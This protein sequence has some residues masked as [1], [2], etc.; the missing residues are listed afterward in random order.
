MELKLWYERQAEKWT[1]AMP[2][3]N[4]R[5]GAMVHGGVKEEKI[6]FNEDTLWS[7]YPHDKNEPGMHVYYR[8][9][10][11][12]AREHRYK[13]AQQ[14][15]EEQFTGG[16]TESYMP[17]GDMYLKMEHG[18]GSSY[19][20]ELDLRTG[21]HKVSYRADGGNYKRT[22][23][24]SYPAQ[25]FVM[26]LESERKG[27]LTFS[28]TF[29]SQLKYTVSSGEGNLE[30]RGLCPSHAD[31]HYLG[32]VNAIFYSDK[33]EE[34]GIRYFS[35]IQVEAADG[36]VESRDGE[37][38]VS[39][40]TEALICLGVRSNFAGI[41][42]CPEFA[43]KDYE[44]PCRRDVEAAVKKGFGALLEEQEKD[45][46]SYFDRVSFSLGED[47]KAGISTYERLR[48]FRDTGD[49]HWLPV[50]LF[51]FGRYLTISASRPGS[52][53]TNLQGI[54][55]DS[56]LPPWSSNYTININTEM[57]YWP[58][59]SCNLAEMNE[60]LVELIRGIS[61]KGKGTAERYYA[62]PGF[63]SHH[64]TDL[65]RSANP[66][67]DKRS[68]CGCWAYWPMSSGWL[69][70]H[71]YTQ[72]EYTLDREFLERTAYPIM[73]EAAL[74]Y[75]AVLEEEG[76]F[77]AFGP[78]T[79]P[80]NSFLWEG[81]AVAVSR[82]NAMT[83]TI[84]RE[85]FENC[86]KAGE[87]LGIRDEFQESLE[88]ALGKLEPLVIGKDGRLLEWNE[89]LPEAEPEHRHLSHLY[90]MFPA[91]LIT[92]EETPEL[93]EACKKSLLARGFEG[94][95]WSLGWKVNLWARLREGGNALR[96]IKR[97]LHLAEDGQSGTCPDFFG[98]HPP[99]QIDGNFGV[100]SGI[101]EMLLQSRK[102]QILL[103]PALPAEWSEGSIRG[104]CAKGGIEAD[105][106]WSGGRLGTVKLRFARDVDVV[107]RYKDSAMDEESVLKIKG[108]AGQDWQG[109]WKN[110]CLVPE[111]G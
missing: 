23:F 51:Q 103:L 42:A 87:V 67:G 61:E 95:G 93:A 92:L 100:T 34:T 37:I 59:F 97:Q 54:W 90:G 101:A 30:V 24:I 18:E 79:S 57:N 39:G 99:F 17:M 2:L 45:F 38:R 16:F 62:A 96:L 60:P 12:L 71:L 25:V 111:E 102:G 35:L 80:E 53:A 109:T 36:A 1:E 6:C 70:E 65:W 73:K 106:A 8:Q 21:V 9:A 110:G 84:I 3:G 104:L 81:G 29:N 85:L 69:C 82:T 55:N 98:S 20:R 105:L 83:M 77:L 74:F 75:L 108:R 49:D 58:V 26:R 11:E 68:G 52:Q 4:G 19:R 7:G 89:E 15:L 47:E 94:T 32:T 33:K 66:V 44:E 13:E 22:T 88:A 56:T 31:P 27:G 40:A 86:R 107:L 28:L 64:N 50:Y 76:G 46:S 48:S 78:S 14:L 10:R 5:I 43:G 91:D 41:D 63:V 72:Y